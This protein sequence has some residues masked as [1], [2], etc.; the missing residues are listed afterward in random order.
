MRNRTWL[1]S[2]VLGALSLIVVRQSLAALPKPGPEVRKLAVMVGRFRNEGHVRAGAFGSNSPAMNVR[3]IDECRWL[4][5]GFGL[6]CIE[7]VD[8]GRSKESETG[9][10]YYNSASKQYEYHGVRNT[11]E[12]TNQA[13][14]VSGDTWTWLGEGALAGHLFHIRYVEKFASSDAYEYTEE[15][16]EGKTPMETGVSGRDARVAATKA[17]TPRQAK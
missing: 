10:I 5:N 8:I 11:G 13:G 9:V 2:V 12:I 16:G 17:G 4:A 15:W 6:I 7:T 1:L 3:G 14:T